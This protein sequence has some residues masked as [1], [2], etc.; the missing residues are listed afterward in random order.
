MIRILRWTTALFYFL[1]LTF[2]LLRP[3]PHVPIPLF[4]HADKVAHFFFLGLLGLLLL[5]ALTDPRRNRP[6]LL[7]CVLACLLSLAYAVAI[8]FIQPS[9]GREYSVLDMLA[10]AA[11]ILVLT[12]LWI[13]LRTR[14]FI[15]R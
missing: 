10:G 9:F 2:L 5:R 13:R 15:L 6:P 12:F 1:I 7:A 14:F 4:P 8:E 11:G 3:L